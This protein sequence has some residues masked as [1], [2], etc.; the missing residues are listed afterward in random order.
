MLSLT[1]ST[2]TSTGSVRPCAGCPSTA[3]VSAWWGGPGAQG[4]PARGTLHSWSV[5]SSFVEGPVQ[6]VLQGG[7][8]HSLLPAQGQSG[9][10]DPMQPGHQRYLCPRP[11][12]GKSPLV[13][14]S[15]LSCC[16]AVV[17]GFLDGVAG[18]T[19]CALPPG[20]GCPSGV[21]RAASTPLNLPPWIFLDILSPSG[22]CTE[23]PCE[24]VL[25][26]F[27]RTLLHRNL[28]A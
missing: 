26:Q 8:E 5:S 11:L 21:P 4:I 3:E 27:P 9:G 16:Q 10:R 24:G 20:S 28:S 19:T 14:P 23:L 22:A 2:S 25:Q 18:V 17:C 6:A 13:F 12:P 1:G 15:L 7:H